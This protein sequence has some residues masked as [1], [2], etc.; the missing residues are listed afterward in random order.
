MRMVDLPRRL[1]PDIEISSIPEKPGVY[2]WFKPAGPIYA[3]KAS[4]DGGLRDRLRKHLG[5]G[6][7]LGR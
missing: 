1:V 5:V 2:A 6:L 7:D 4:G 3:G